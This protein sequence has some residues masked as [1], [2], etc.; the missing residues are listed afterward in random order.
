MTWKPHKTWIEQCEAARGI[1]DYDTVGDLV[2]LEIKDAS[3]RVPEAGKIE[4]QAAI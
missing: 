1:F 3:K 4:F 2:S